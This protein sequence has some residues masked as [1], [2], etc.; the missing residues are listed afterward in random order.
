MAAPTSDKVLPPL[1]FLAGLL[2]AFISITIAMT[3]TISSNLESDWTAPA[4]RSMPAYL[5]AFHDGTYSI[6]TP[7]L[8]KV[9]PDNTTDSWPFSASTDP[10][11]TTFT[12]PAESD[13]PV[14]MKGISGYWGGGQNR[15]DLY[16]VQHGGWLGWQTY[17]QILRY[18]GDYVPIINKTTGLQDAL[19]GTIGLRHEYQVVI[20]GYSESSMTLDEQIRA[21]NFNV[22]FMHALNTTLSANPWVIIGQFFSFDLPGMPTWLNVLIAAPI[23]L[24]IGVCAFIIIRG[25]LPT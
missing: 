9:D 4:Y 20:G 5:S 6:W 10:Y 13:F 24:I 25:A 22:T 7:A 16:F 12:N 11:Q 17:Q 23:Y 14:E 15:T 21:W 18:P 8:F 19:R 2:A 3:P 1:L